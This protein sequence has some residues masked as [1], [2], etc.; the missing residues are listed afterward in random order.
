MT[1]DFPCFG[2][3][4]DCAEWVPVPHSLCAPCRAERDRRAALLDLGPAL[5]ERR[6][7]WHPVG[8]D[9]LPLPADVCPARATR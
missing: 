2:T 7:P 9:P 4:S 5:R 1:D 8:L 3:A 6:A